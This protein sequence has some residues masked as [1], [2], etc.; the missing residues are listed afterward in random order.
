[1]GVYITT[2]LEHKHN[3][4][5]MRAVYKNE[6][7]VGSDTMFDNFVKNGCQSMVTS[8]WISNLN[9]QR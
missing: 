7:I 8:K 4:D 9:K 3:Y 5:S 2:C 6:N 1:M